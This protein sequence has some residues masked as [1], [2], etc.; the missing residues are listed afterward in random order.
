MYICV[1]ISFLKKGNK[2]QKNKPYF[3]YLR[4]AAV[5]KMEYNC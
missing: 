4:Y 3:T 1:Y 5:S 2:F